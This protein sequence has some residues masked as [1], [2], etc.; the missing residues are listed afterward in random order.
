MKMDWLQFALKLPMVI[1]GIMS[2]VQKVQG[3]SGSQKKAA[4]LDAIPDSV[5]LIEFAA[6]RDLLKDET[7]A[8]L[9]STYIDA[10][11]VAL[12][13]RE[14]LK[15]GILSKAPTEPPANPT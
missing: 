13:A 4:V 12:K 7:I 3:A 11:K 8:G 15:A 6:G 10:E 1:G 14:A 9:V 5:S 2:I